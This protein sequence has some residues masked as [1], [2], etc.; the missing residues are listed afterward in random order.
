[1]QPEIEAKFLNV[2]H[3]TVRQKLAQLGAKREKPMRLMR[4]TMFDYPDNRIEQ[5]AKG[6]LRVRDEGDKITITY[7][8]PRSDRYSDEIETTVDSYDT[9]VKLLQAIG[10]VVVSVQESKRET[11]HY[12]NVEIELDAWPWAKP[13]VEIEGKAEA[14]IKACAAEL[15]FDWE[16]AVFGAAESAYRV[17]YPG[18]KDNETIDAMTEIRFNAPLPAWLEKRRAA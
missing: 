6:R 3:D 17:E 1:M 10:L 11:W 13:Y 12:R 9:M 4:R 14:D 5:I 2:N 18:I 15:G 8:R 7:K 16:A